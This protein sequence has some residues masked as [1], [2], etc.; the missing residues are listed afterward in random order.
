MRNLLLIP[1][2]FLMAQSAFAS[3]A[4]FVGTGTVSSTPDYVELSIYVNSECYKSTS[5]ARQA[6]DNVASEIVNFLKMRIKNTG[7][8]KNKIITNGGY[9]QPF[10]KYINNQH[11][12]RQVCLGTFQ[13]R[14][15]ITIRTSD[16]ANFSELFDEIQDLVYSSYKQSAPNVDE[17]V[18]YV[19]LDAPQTRITR[20]NN[21]ILEKTALG[22]ALKNAKERLFA[23]FGCEPL[24]VEIIDM[25]ETQASQTPQT[26]SYAPK[27]MRAMAMDSGGG[28]M[29][30]AAPIEFDALLV[31]KNI[32]VKFSFIEK[33]CE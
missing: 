32:Y 29:E 12:S 25:S 21:A 10:S 31:S 7:D 18:N 22:L 20:E 2:A 28:Q 5:L 19:T 6:T 15:T 8:F 23:A 33:P 16:V 30:A 17:P 1:V 11:G 26:H 4:Y 9:T 24:R 13:K 3:E 27:M 14:T